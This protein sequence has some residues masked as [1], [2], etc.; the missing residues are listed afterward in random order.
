M[1]QQ[2]EFR[3]FFN[4][5]VFLHSMGKSSSYTSWAK[6]LAVIGAVLAVI[7]IAMTYTTDLMKILLNT[8]A[9]LCSIVIIMQTRKGKT[10]SGFCFVWWQLLVFLCLQVILISYGAGFSELAVL[11]IALEAIADILLILR[12]L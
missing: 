2:I 11:G 6:V 10:R 12:D 5:C 4:D 3:I 8:L 1:L 9:I 7:G